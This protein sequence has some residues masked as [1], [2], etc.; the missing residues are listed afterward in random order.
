[1]FFFRQHDGPRGNQ[2]ARFSHEQRY[3]KWRGYDQIILGRVRDELPLQNY[4]SRSNR[5][6]SGSSGMQRQAYLQRAGIMASVGLFKEMLEDLRLALDVDSH[7]PLTDAERKI[8]C[9]IEHQRIL[10]DEVIWKPQFIRE[11]KESC[12][13]RA[14]QDVLLLLARHVYWHA[15]Y[16]FKTHAYEQMLRALRSLLGLLLDKNTARMVE[17]WRRVARISG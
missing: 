6:D 1:M 5:F 9:D 10:D 11:L 16:R 2:A 3:A 12:A 15:R 13:G 8:F 14:G 4:L 7:C 17:R